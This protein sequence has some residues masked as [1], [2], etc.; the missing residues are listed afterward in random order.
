MILNHQVWWTERNTNPIPSTKNCIKK[1]KKYFKI[2]NLVQFN[3]I[4]NNIVAFVFK[5]LNII[6]HSSFYSFQLLWHFSAK[7]RHFLDALIN[8]ISYSKNVLK[9]QEFPRFLPSKYTR[10]FPKKKNNNKERKYLRELLCLTLAH[11]IFHRGK[12]I[13]DS[14]FRFSCSFFFLFM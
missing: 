6:L 7:K 1:Y 11:K 8:W 14:T 2:S 12:K 3:K 4:I 9:C 13:Y 5:Y 10:M